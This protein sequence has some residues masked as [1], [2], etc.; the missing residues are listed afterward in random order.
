MFHVACVRHGRRALQREGRIPNPRVRY[1]VEITR[2][3]KAQYG[4][5]QRLARTI[6]FLTAHAASCV[7]DPNP[8]FARAL[9]T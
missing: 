6:P 2:S 1:S 3:F 5:I 9:A 7:R 4:E 8:S